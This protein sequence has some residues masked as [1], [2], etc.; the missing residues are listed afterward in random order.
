MFFMP[1][2]FNVPKQSYYIYGPVMFQTTTFYYFI[3]NAHPSVSY[4][5]ERKK[6]Y[7]NN[8]QKKSYTVI[9]KDGHHFDYKS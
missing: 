8:T 1:N 4:C 9:F 2:F 3:L 5:I 6:T 7:H